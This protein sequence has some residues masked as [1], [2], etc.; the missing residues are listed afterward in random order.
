MNKD[1]FDY[2]IENTQVILA[3]Q[4]QIATF[5]ST[6]FHFYL[7]SELMDRVN[8]VRVRNGKIHADRPQILTPEHF[9]RLLLEGF[10]DKAQRYVDQLREQARNFAVLRYGFQFRK[11]DVTERMFRDPL[12]AVIARTKSQVEDME[13]P[14][15]AIIQGVDDAWEV[16]LLKFTID[17]IERSSGGNLGD[18]R[19]RGLL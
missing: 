14:L 3:P 18:F 16:C 17:M 1:N 2:A 9:S 5:G 15:S 10:G 12:D 6:S 8:E 13:E 7:I 4:R 19:K 11:T